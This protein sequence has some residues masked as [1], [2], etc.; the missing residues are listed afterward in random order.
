MIVQ[1]Y[2]FHCDR[3]EKPFASEMSRMVPGCPPF[4]PTRYHTIFGM[5][6]CDV[7][8][9]LIGAVMDEAMKV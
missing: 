1:R 2:E 3:C 4:N 6:L 8:R 5:E 9:P 7:C